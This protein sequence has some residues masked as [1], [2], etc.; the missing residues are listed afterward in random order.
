MAL[1][2]GRE[3]TPGHLLPVQQETSTADV[4]RM[5]T[6]FQ[7]ILNEAAYAGRA[8][9]LPQRLKRSKPRKQPNHLLEEGPTG[10]SALLNTHTG[11]KCNLA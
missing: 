1:W 2:T 4:A 8:Q 7:I 10:N 5:P 9:M 3:L 11:R 6:Y